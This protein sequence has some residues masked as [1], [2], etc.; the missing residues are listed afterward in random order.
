MKQL[1]RFE[2]FYLEKGEEKQIT[3]ALT[4]DDLSIVN[5]NMRRVVETGTFKI[6]IGASSDDIR[7]TECIC[8]E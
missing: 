1:K 2:R 5:Q 3:F 8:I 4:E 7:L 6:M